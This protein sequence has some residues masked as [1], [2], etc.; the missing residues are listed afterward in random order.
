MPSSPHDPGLSLGELLEGSGW[1]PILAPDSRQAVRNALREFS[2]ATGEAVSH[3]GEVPHGWCGVLDGLIKLASVD[4]EGRGVTFTGLAPGGWFGEA[5][6]L[7]EAP[8]SVDAVAL[9]ASRIVM[10]PADV[11]FQLLQA[12]FAFSRFIMTLLSERLHWFMG[13][14]Y[15]NRT[16]DS[17]ARVARALVGLFQPAACMCRLTEL[18]ISQEELA[19]IAGV[20]R[21][22]CNRALRELR[23]ARLLAVDYGIMRLLDAGRLRRLVESP[24]PGAHRQ[25]AGTRHS[26][27]AGSAEHAA[28]GQRRA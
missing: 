11:F 6:L 13:H 25:R 17:H 8:F 20:S 26:A 4:T 3:Q 12:D 28:R 22:S 21:Q 24:A 5:T 23:E 16:H 18:R 7:R 15:A 14:C 10:L 27:H 1:F 9:R 2:V 19:Y